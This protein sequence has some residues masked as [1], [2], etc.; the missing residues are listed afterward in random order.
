MKSNLLTKYHNGRAPTHSIIK[1]RLDSID[2][3]LYEIT[4][5]A[6]NDRSLIGPF[7]CRHYSGTRWFT[8]AGLHLY[9]S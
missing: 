6:S 9:V 7:P 3:K 4:Y 2:G 8:H 1:G 5:I